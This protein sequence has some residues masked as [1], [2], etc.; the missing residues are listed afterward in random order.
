MGINKRNND[1]Q[2]RIRNQK[3][4]WAFQVITDFVT[5]PNDS[6]SRYIE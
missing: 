2:K 5:K 4:P 3:R 6:K 1:M